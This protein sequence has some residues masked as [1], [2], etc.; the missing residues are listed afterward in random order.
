MT[1]LKTGL[2]TIL[3]AAGGFFYSGAAVAATIS[4]TVP[5]RFESLTEEVA[6]IEIKCQV[7][8]QRV[9][10]IQGSKDFIPDATGNVL[11]TAVIDMYVSIPA[12][13]QGQS[14]AELGLLWS[15]DAYVVSKTGKK[16]QRS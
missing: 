16:G 12:S 4:I 10:V 2:L 5:V 3:L 15:C 1:K 6:K 7:Y 11:Q 9:A 8:G 14:P 13:S